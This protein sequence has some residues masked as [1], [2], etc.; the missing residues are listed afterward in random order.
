MRVHG[1]T[2]RLP[3]HALKLD[4]V[5]NLV[6]FLSNYAEENA[7]LLPGRIPGYKRD[8]VQLLPSNTTKKVQDIHT[9]QY[10]PY[11]HRHTPPHILAH[12]DTFDT[13]TCTHSIHTDIH[14]TYTHTLKTHRCTHTHSTDVHPPYSHTQ[15]TDT[16]THTHIL[17]H[18]LP[19]YTT[20]RRTPPTLETQIH[21]HTHILRHTLPPPPPIHTHTDRHT[22]TNW[23]K[24]YKSMHCHCNTIQHTVCDVIYM[25]TDL[26]YLHSYLYKLGSLGPVQAV[27]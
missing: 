26:L 20:H 25:Y 15:N 19:P 22:H 16:H 3:K 4:E 13:Y 8:D 9:Q 21:T 10:T 6:A 18:T 27:S 7:I 14:P 1:N 11:T 23:T 24:F 2:R 5:K 12:R 17:Q